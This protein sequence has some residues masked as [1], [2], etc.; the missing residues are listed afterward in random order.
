MP[1]ESLDEVL[2]EEIKDLYDAEKQLV[3]ALPKMA[4]AAIN[5]ELKE[6]FEEHLEQTKG[7]VQRLEQVFEHLEMKPKGKTC[8]AM[9]GLVTEASEHIKE[10]LNGPLG[11]AQLITC[12]QKVEHYEIAGYGNVRAIA[13]ALGY[14]EVAELLQSTLEEEKEADEKLTEVG[15]FI[16]EEAIGSAGESEEE[17]VEAEEKTAMAAKPKTTAARGK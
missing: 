5:S 9:K 8:Q 6:G 12:A 10:K 13:E 17:E 3:Q 4:K 2:L 16:L 11:D 1:V 14:A 15:Q 7:H